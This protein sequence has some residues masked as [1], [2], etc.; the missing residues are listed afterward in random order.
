[1]GEANN[2][3][4]MKLVLELADKHEKINKLIDRSYFEEKLKNVK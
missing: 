1:M 4:S 2:N 3:M